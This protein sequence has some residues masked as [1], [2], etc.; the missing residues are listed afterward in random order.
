MILSN[1][2]MVGTGL[3][4]GILGDLL[5]DSLLSF[6]NPCGSPPRLIFGENLAGILLW[7]RRAN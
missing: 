1:S 3:G 6:P 7:I 4:L 2:N 5:K